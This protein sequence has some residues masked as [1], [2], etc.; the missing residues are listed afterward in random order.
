M[1]ATSNIILYVIT[2]LT[3]N[4]KTY[5][6]Q[7]YRS[8]YFASPSVSP[9]RL[10]IVQ[11]YEKNELIAEFIIGNEFKTSVIKFQSFM[12]SYGKDSRG[13][14]G[15]MDLTYQSWPIDNAYSE[16]LIRAFT[17]LDTIVALKIFR[18]QCEHCK[19]LEPIFYD[20]AKSAEFSHIRFIQANIDN[21]PVFK[22]DMKMRLSGKQI[23]EDSR[24]RNE[25]CETCANSGYVVCTSCEGAGTVERGVNVLFCAECMGNLMYPALPIYIR[26]Y[27][28]T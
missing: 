27:Y 18:D 7:H 22:A 2:F 19:L 4:S 3:V 1:L 26:S 15:T 20:M 5:G 9:I 21:I 16:S 11:V 10:P 24:T 25:I 17:A 12:N 8:T 6:Q 23:S 28:T 13:R 14:L